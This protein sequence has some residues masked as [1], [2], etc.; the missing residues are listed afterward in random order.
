L[1]EIAREFIADKRIL[2]LLRGYMQHVVYD[3][4]WYYDIE[5]GISS[6]CPLSPLMVALYLHKLDQKMAASGLFYAR[7]MD[8]WMILAP[9]AGSFGM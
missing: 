2:K 7:F 5:K 1:L 8:D 9:S 4:T 6:G 3:D